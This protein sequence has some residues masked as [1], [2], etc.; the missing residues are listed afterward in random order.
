V[1]RTLVSTAIATILAIGLCAPAATAR[2]AVGSGGGSGVVKI[3]I[4][5]S[6][7]RRFVPRSV[8]V[9][10]GTKIRWV[11]AGSLSHTTTANGGG[12]DARLDPGETFTRK[13]RRSG[14]FAF[15]CTIHPTM[16]GTITVT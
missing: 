15:H 12:W 5:D 16:T 3:K 10:R 6:G 14:T 1:K 2:P 9:E 13:F 7:T 4:K 11:N 8:T